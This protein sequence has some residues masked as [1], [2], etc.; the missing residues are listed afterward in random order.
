MLKVGVAPLFG[1]FARQSAARR[2]DESS[3]GEGEGGEGRRPERSD[4]SPEGQR[5]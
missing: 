5:W 2:H 4:V 3:L 1:D